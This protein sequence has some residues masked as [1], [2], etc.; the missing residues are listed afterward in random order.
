MIQISDALNLILPNIVNQIVKIKY[1]SEMSVFISSSIILI[2]ALI[3]CLLFVGVVLGMVYCCWSTKLTGS[4]CPY[5][6][7]FT[8][9]LT[10]TKVML[11]L[12]FH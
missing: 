4:G 5:G 12:K 3:V 11:L 6:G 1:Q 8:F 10:F 2:M 7:T 9:G